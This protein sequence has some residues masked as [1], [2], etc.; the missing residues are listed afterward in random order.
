MLLSFDVLSSIK[1][2]QVPIVPVRKLK[3]AVGSVFR[4]FTA[5]ALGGLRVRRPR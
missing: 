2:A 5:L 1:K 4:N 3:E